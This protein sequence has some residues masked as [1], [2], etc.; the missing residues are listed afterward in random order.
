MKGCI[1]DG[2]LSSEGL[3]EKKNSFWPRKWI[4]WFIQWKINKKNLQFKHWISNNNF[5][6]HIL[7][8]Y[9]SISKTDRISISETKLVCLKILLLPIKIQSAHL[10]VS[11]YNIYSRRQ[12][13]CFCISMRTQK[14][15]DDPLHFCLLLSTWCLEYSLLF[16]MHYS[17]W[18]PMKL[19][20]KDVEPHLNDLNEMK[21]QFNWK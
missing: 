21:F 16:L 18:H 3:I 13:T 1:L 20:W 17:P 15:H 10:S 5:S 4:I 7:L 11:Q 8:R 19:I 12:E 14:D 9:S 6:Q 2:S